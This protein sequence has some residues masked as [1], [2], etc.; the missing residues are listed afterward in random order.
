[1]EFSPGRGSAAERGEISDTDGSDN[2][3]A[4]GALEERDNRLEICIIRGQAERA[5]SG[6]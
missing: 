3:S 5:D 4:V 1:M 6:E 2:I